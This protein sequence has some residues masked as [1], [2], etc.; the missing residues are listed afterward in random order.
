ML[1]LGSPDVAAALPWQALIEAIERIAV[2]PNAV[3]PERTLHSLP[4]PD[5]ADATLLLKPAWVVGGSIVVKGVAVHPDNGARGLPMVNAGVL[6]LDASTGVVI[7]A[8]DGNELTT[9]RT[10]A[11]SA[12]AARRLARDDAHHLLV[13]GT[14]AL[15]PRALE[16]HAHVRDYHRISVWG[17]R[18]DAAAALIDDVG[19]AVDV[20]MVA[21]AD[22]DAAVAAAD[23]ITCATGSTESLVTGELL[24]PGTHVD[25]IGAF[26]ASMRES[27]DATIARASVW[28]DTVEDALLAGDLAQP[29]ASGT[30][31]ADQIKGDLRSLVAGPE[32]ARVDA[33]EITVFKSVGTALED[34]AAAELVFG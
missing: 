7:G 13:V 10:A 27:D 14:G 15:A 2:D 25:L 34:L 22:L 18:P 30:F 21:V 33:D 16:A 28:V 5:G 29:I 31:G 8:C 9:R 11:A 23:V 3:S 24:R 1:A 4:V 26:N 19:S 6:L 32:S 12:V 20:E 17:R